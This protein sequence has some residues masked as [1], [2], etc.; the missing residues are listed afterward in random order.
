MQQFFARMSPIRAWHDLRLFLGTRQPQDLWFLL[1]SITLTCFILWAFVHDSYAEK[2]YKPKIVYFEQWKLDRTDA[3]IIAQQKID[4]P[5][6]DAQI[7]AQRARE[8]KLR[9]GFKRL[10]DKL[11]AMGI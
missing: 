5:I 7:A 10:D 4:K 6:R 1:L 8:E 9:A 3:E 2:V 11:N